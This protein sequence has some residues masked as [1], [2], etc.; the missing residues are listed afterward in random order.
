MKMSLS[1]KLIYSF[2]AVVGISVL[3]VA[4]LFVMLSGVKKTNQHLVQEASPKALASFEVDK[5]INNLVTS[6]KIAVLAGKN[7][8]EAEL[9]SSQDKSWNA[10]NQ[11]LTV[12]KKNV[13]TGSKDS[14]LVNSLSDQI[15]K[16]TSVLNHINQTRQSVDNVPSFLIQSQEAGPRAANIL[17]AISAI[18]DEE[19]TLEST[20]ERKALL[21]QLADTRGSFAT[22]YGAL[23]G[24]LLT[25]DERY[26]KTFDGKWKVNIRAF[27]TIEKAKH[28][29][30]PTQLENWNRYVSIRSEFAPLP[31]KMYTARMAEDWNKAQFL[32]TKE[33]NPVAQK[34]QSITS[35][36]VS[37]N[38]SLLRTEGEELASSINLMNW[39]QILSAI[40][41]VVT[42]VVIV[43]LITRNVV[44]VTREIAESS[45]DVSL[46]S[47][48]ISEGSQK[49]AEG[50]NIQASSIESVSASMEEMAAMTSQNADNA[51][52]AKVLAGQAQESASQGQNTMGEMQRA[53]HAIK[54]S[55]DQTA[56]I[57]KTID[58]IAFQTNLLALNA[59]VEAARAGEAG[60][61]F[62]VVAEEV[63]S[64]AQRSADAA[65]DTA[66]LIEQAVE[67]ANGGVRITES[68]STLFETIND[69]STR[70][71]NLI[72]EI[73]SASKE[74]AEGI[75][76]VSNSVN[77]M[78][79][80]IQEN[81]S[82]SEESAAASQELSTQAE[83]LLSL[84]SSLGGGEQSVS[85]KPKAKTSGGSTN[86]T[87]VVTPKSAVSNPPAT[88]TATKAQ[89]KASAPAKSAS[90]EQVIP[91]D[92]DEFLDF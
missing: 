24:M 45:E 59:A 36:L 6:M 17:K 21:K 15:S 91:L 88:S 32:L 73:A 64:L 19:G 63:R 71:A 57:V 86:W 12:I 26:K 42:S 11:A 60:K 61:G 90:P 92:D 87:S 10:L 70:V 77:D 7:A 30:S 38:S 29:F 9:K 83:L 40:I 20:S 31:Q 2:A 72:T 58:D 1:K 39:I 54:E 65:K 33:L 13:Q 8:D 46:T 79:Q 47:G 49:L 75:N 53:I 69:G 52:E 5:E 76:Q 84:V 3:S 25:G 28:L 41:A 37:R 78:N 27:E 44:R 48:H 80:V 89:P 51:S 68:V 82:N 85:Q 4:V 35:T 74:Q 62:A 81:A 16:V 66:D 14:Q 23:N 50:A 22:G 34:I 67:N 43:S 55:S 18:I 56:K